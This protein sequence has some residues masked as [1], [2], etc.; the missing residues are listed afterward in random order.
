[1]VN[2]NNTNKQSPPFRISSVSAPT[3]TRNTRVLLSAKH[4]DYGYSKFAQSGD[5]SLYVSVKPIALCTYQTKFQTHHSFLFLDLILYRQPP[6]DPTHP[7]IISK[8]ID[9]EYESKICRQAYAPGKH[10]TVPALPNVTVVN[11]LGDFDIAMDRLAII[12][13]EGMYIIIVYLNR[14]PC[15]SNPLISYF[16]TLVYSRSLETR[17]SA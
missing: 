2:R 14:F 10:F 12:D 5:I 9:L 6:P 8:R 15:V 4:G 7:R 1:M 13:G 17:H 11:E 16:F 3:T